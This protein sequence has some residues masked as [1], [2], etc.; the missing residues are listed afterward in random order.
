[1][2]KSER[3]ADEL[4]TIAKLIAGLERAAT[5]MTTLVRLGRPLDLRRQPGTDLE[6][7]LAEALCGNPLKAAEGSYIGDFDPAMLSE[8][9]KTITLGG[10]ASE[11][12]SAASPAVC[13]RR[14]QTST[15]PW[16]LIE[17]RGVIQ[18]A[19]DGDIF[20]SFVGA[21]GL[22]LALA[23]KIIQAHGGSATQ[24]ANTLRVRLPLEE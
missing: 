24:E 7:L 18:D 11:G 1:M 16:A 21:P 19:A 20:H 15:Q 2:E 8:A 17:W 23:A 13:L 9:L 5:D 12:L 14:D 22:R 6:R 3:P 4:E 10:R